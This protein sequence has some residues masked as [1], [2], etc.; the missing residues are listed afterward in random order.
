MSKTHT[1]VYTD[2]DMLLQHSPLNESLEFT[3][4]G[5]RYS[6]EKNRGKI[7]IKE[8]PRNP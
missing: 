7:L 3:D 6:S 2:L 1:I 5:N 8:T 4:S